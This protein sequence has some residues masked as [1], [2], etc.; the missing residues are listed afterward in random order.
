MVSAEPQVSHRLR[1]LN[2]AQGN[3]SLPRNRTPLPRGVPRH[4]MFRGV[5]NAA[6]CAVRTKNLMKGGAYRPA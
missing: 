6:L 5:D 2:T 3:S 4:T 1:H